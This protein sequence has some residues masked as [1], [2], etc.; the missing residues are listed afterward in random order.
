MKRDPGYP[1]ELVNALRQQRA[2]ANDQAAAAM[3]ENA[4]LTEKLV[5]IAAELADFK[6]PA[7]TAPDKSAGGVE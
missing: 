7:N 4:L 2:A 1:Q 6:K 3:A 5:L